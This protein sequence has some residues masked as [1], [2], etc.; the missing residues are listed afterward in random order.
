MRLTYI[1]HSGFTIEADGYAILIDYFKDSG[2]TPDTGFVHDELLHRAGTLYILSSHFHSDHFNPDI[3][4]WKE[5]KPDIKYIFSKDI[6]KRKRANAED[7]TYL[8]KGDVFEDEH[9]RIQAFGSTDVG[10]SFLI[11]PVGGIKLVHI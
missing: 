9:L 7:A 10:I 6:L 11:E 3:L 1:Y 2:K 4:K 5:I 8:K